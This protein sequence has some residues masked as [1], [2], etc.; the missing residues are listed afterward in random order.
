MS[1]YLLTQAFN[2]AE[3]LFVRFIFGADMTGLIGAAR[4]IANLAN[5]AASSFSAILG[6]RAAR[7]GI[8]GTSRNLECVAGVTALI[9]TVPLLIGALGLWLGNDGIV[10]AILGADY[11]ASWPFLVIM[12]SF[13][14]VRFM[15]GLP[16]PIMFVRSL[17]REV[18]ISYIMGLLLLFGFMILAW[19]G[20]SPFIA[21]IGQGLALCVQ[22][23]YLWV[24]LKRREGIRVDVFAATRCGRTGKD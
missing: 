23:G 16:I 21:V 20:D 19:S 2:N 24:M 6:P 10:R 9:L 1:S 4:R 22:F 3:I 18:T 11:V 12:L 5:M 13:L 8:E 17:E 14:G 15:F 7:E